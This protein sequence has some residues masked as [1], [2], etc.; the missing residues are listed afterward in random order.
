MWGQTRL[1]ERIRKQEALI[2]SLQCAVTDLQTHVVEY[3]KVIEAN[4]LAIDMHT[5][6]NKVAADLA[7]TRRS[8]CRKGDEFLEKV[9]NLHAEDVTK[10]FGILKADIASELNK[11]RRRAIALEPKRPCPGAK[12]FHDE[13]ETYVYC[14]ECRP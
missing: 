6:L 3:H 10:R 13:D 11:L 5:T 2:D 7:E 14:E 9:L 12:K 4:T 1:R 8:Q